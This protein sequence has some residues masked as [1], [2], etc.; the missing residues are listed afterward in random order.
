MRGLHPSQIFISMGERSSAFLPLPQEIE[1][2]SI[3]EN[4]LIFPLFHQIMEWTAQKIG[5]I[6]LSIMKTSCHTST[7]SGMFVQLQFCVK[8]ITFSVLCYFSAVWV[9][10]K[11]KMN[12]FP[13]SCG[14]Y[15]LIILC[16]C[17]AVSRKRKS[18]ECRI[19]VLNIDFFFFF[20]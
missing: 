10:K 15:F 3:D 5:I 2:L 18:M 9:A 12:F 20:G 16:V 6:F 8:G 19:P 4:H 11:E 1:I 17:G 7:P 13:L 14:K